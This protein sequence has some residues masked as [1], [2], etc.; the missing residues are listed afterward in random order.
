MGLTTDDIGSTNELLEEVW[1]VIGNSYTLL[2]GV[3]LTTDDI[4]STKTLLEYAWLVAN[5][6]L[7]WVGLITD[8]IVSPNALLEEAWLVI[9]NILLEGVELITESL[10]EEVWLVIDK[11]YT[12]LKEVWPVTD[13]VT[14]LSTLFE[15]VGLSMLEVR[16]VLITSPTELLLKETWTVDTDKFVSL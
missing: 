2:E 5:T 16:D 4:G 7:E 6:M 15:A 8:D 11:S 9:D 12:L 13:K 1:L 3:E 14:L 10:L